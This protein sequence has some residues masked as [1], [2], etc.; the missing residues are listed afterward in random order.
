MDPKRQQQFDSKTPISEVLKQEQAGFVPSAPK[1]SDVV[2][3]TSNIKTDTAN[4]S[5][6]TPSASQIRIIKTYRSDAAEA[7]K[8]QQESVTKIAIAEAEQRRDLGEGTEATPKRKT[9]LL[10]T[11]IILIAIGAAAIPTVQYI[12]NQKTKEVTVVTEKTIIPFDHQET[13]TV[14]NATRE[15]FS[16]ALDEFRAKPP[17]T[18]TIEYVK[19]LENIQDANKKTVTQKIAPNI[20]AGIIGP[21]MPSALARSFDSDYMYGIEDSNNPKSFIIFKT[22]SYQQTFANMLR[23]ETK[24]INDLNPILKIN[25]DALGRPFTDQ[26]LINKDV[27]A[28]TSPDGSIILLYG[29]LDNQTLV[30]TTSAETFQNINSRY[31]ATRFVQ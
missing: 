8:I 13:L 21:N 12:L 26:V 3:A 16:N 10:L 31:V 6:E 20:F 22:S 23:W 27:R 7:A 14:N 29:F 15:D 11:A 2:S 9:G 19:I 18:S 1:L 5:G 30:I 28:V 17:V 25:T 24:M 4:Q